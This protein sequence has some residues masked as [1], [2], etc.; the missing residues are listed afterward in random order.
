[1]SIWVEPDK[2]T[3]KDLWPNH[4]QRLELKYGRS[5]GLDHKRQDLEIRSGK[6]MSNYMWIHFFLK[7]W[8]MLHEGKISGSKIQSLEQAKN[9][10]V[11]RYDI[12]LKN[13]LV[14]LLNKMIFKAS[15][16]KS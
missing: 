10:C 12:L 6:N 2:N 15:N 7:S 1:M 9:S 11:K 5:P 16:P 13:L 4:L 14:T 8:F 3:L